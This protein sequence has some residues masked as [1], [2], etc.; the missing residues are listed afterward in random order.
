ML[1]AVTNPVSSTEAILELEEYQVTDLFA[2]SGKIVHFRVLLLPT[3]ILEE[4]SSR[5]IEV[6]SI[7]V[8]GLLPQI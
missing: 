1:L 6:G 2:F 8:N 5:E 7:E 4:V 3:L